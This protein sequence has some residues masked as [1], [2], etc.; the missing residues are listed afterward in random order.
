VVFDVP[1]GGTVGPVRV[2]E[3][4]V[5]PGPI[6]EPVSEPASQILERKSETKSGM[7]V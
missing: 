2:K 6:P 4:I 7:F 5:D 3:S 1:D